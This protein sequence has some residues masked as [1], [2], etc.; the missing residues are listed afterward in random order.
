[1]V[2]LGIRA[3]PVCTHQT[4]ISLF[5]FPPEG[6]HRGDRAG[7]GQ[8]D[9]AHPATEQQGFAAWAR[10][11]QVRNL[12]SPEQLPCACSPNEWPQLEAE[13]V[14]VHPSGRA[15]LRKPYE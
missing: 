2:Q 1:M 12:G 3:V 15:G 5:F 4:I 7:L 9:R 8:G 13:G 10:T 11:A 14:W 6:A